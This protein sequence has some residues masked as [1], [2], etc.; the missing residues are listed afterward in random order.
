IVGVTVTGSGC[1]GGGLDPHAASAAMAKPASAATV[2][3]AAGRAPSPG[4]APRRR[5]TLAVVVRNA[6]GHFL[7][8]PAMPVPLPAL[9]AVIGAR[10]AAGVPGP[11]TLYGAPR[12]SW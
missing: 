8:A 10:D 3:R 7:L 12:L 6:T 5:V 2:A 4:E 1:S 9:L 11:G